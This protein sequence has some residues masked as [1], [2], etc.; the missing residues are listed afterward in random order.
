[1]HRDPGYIMMERP[2]LR[3]DH[4]NSIGEESGF[5]EHDGVSPFSV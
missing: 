2:L 1:M 4:G 5:D 3:I